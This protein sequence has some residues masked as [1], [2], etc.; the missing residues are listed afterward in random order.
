MTPIQKNATFPSPEDG[1]RALGRDDTFSWSRALT[2]PPRCNRMRYREVR[3][4]MAAI[5]DRKS[6]WRPSWIGSRDVIY[7]ITGGYYLNG[8]SDAKTSNGRGDLPHPLNIMYP[9]SKRNK[10]F[11][12]LNLSSKSIFIIIF[13]HYSYSV[14]IMFYIC[15][16]SKKE[17]TT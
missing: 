16:K 3:D 11:P 2:H 13:K 17:H 12:F 8:I 1:H 5:L 7:P 9:N 15:C 14:F 6:C 10:I 4:L